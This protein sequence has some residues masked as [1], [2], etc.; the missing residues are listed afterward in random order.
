[1]MNLRTLSNLFVFNKLAERVGF[2]LLPV[3]S[4]VENRGNAFRFNGLK[5]RI[6]MEI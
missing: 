3:S 5:P 2:G 6:P 4:G 1:M